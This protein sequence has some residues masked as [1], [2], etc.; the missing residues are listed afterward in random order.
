MLDPIIPKEVTPEQRK[1]ISKILF[2][3]R[4]GLLAIGAKFTAGLFIANSIA[5]LIGNY[6]LKDVD[7]EM[8]TGFQFVSITANIIFMT[9]YLDRQFKANNDRVVSRVKE[10]LKNNEPQ[11]NVDE[12]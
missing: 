5:I 9:L 1:E 6:V 2:N 4:L 3:A 7:P 10:I 12:K 11:E 8:R